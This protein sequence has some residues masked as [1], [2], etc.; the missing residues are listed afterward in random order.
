MKRFFLIFAVSV[1]ISF[2]FAGCAGGLNDN[3]EDSYDKLSK[4]LGITSSSNSGD[5][6][7]SDS[8]DNTDKTDDS[9][10]LT[11][12]SI[13]DDKYTL[14]YGKS[15]T[16]LRDI[17]GE[18]G[19]EFFA[20]TGKNYIVFCNDKKDGSIGFNSANNGGDIKFRVCTIRTINGNDYLDENLFD[21]TDNGYTM[22]KEF[23]VSN[24][25]KVALLAEVLES[26]FF[27]IAVVEKDSRSV[28]ELTVSSELN[29]V[30]DTPAI[31]DNNDN[32]L[33]EEN[34]TSGTLTAEDELV[35]SL[36]V[37]SKSLYRIC[38]ECS[39]GDLDF[40]L[41]TSDGKKLFLFKLN[42]FCVFEPRYTSYSSVSGAITLKVHLTNSS[43]TNIKLCVLDKGAY[44]SYGESSG[45]FKT[46][47]VE[48]TKTRQ[49]RIFTVSSDNLD[50]CDFSNC[51]TVTIKLI[52]L[53]GV[54]Y[55]SAGSSESKSEL[56]TLVQK[57]QTS[58]AEFILDLENYT[59][60]ARFGDLASE[61]AFAKTNLISVIMRPCNSYTYIF[62]NCTTLKDVT[63]L[64]SENGLEST[65]NRI[66]SSAFWGCTNLESVKLSNS[67]QSI[68][69][70]AFQDCIKLKSI[71]IPSSVTSIGAYAF[72]NCESLTSIK[73]PSSVEYI[74]AHA[75]EGCTG[76]K[77]IIFENHGWYRDSWEVSGV[78]E[79]LTYLGDSATNVKWFTSSLWT[80]YFWSQKS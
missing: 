38:Y 15:D 44:E 77:S 21:Y 67:V 60:S 50:S 48:L 56:K 59:G 8:N 49:T 26:G 79:E 19:F 22:G 51:D 40:E 11:G 23:S 52:S 61:S 20:Y 78:K 3:N 2:I 28:V 57:M 54:E 18:V 29:V 63:I 9:S 16:A 4:A 32:A 41:Y 34:W 1:C 53:S 25:C 55:H 31:Y 33:A 68:D 65:Q 39:D 62:R 46:E 70:C 27:G 17:N 71:V 30:T 45:V 5:K 13:P 74:F 14:C 75:F 47:P 12:K 7:P 35:Y 73:I 66:C 80:P 36:S 69:D 42:E 24:D 6:V 64:K 10:E 76:L 37:N 72:A 58:E 43:S